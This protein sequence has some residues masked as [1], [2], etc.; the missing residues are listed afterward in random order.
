MIT[1]EEPFIELA[2][3]FALI[4]ESTKIIQEEIEMKSK[5]IARKV[6]IS[7]GPFFNMV[8]FENQLI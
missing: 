1:M 8:P 5:K 7:I 3:Q 2:K 6:K 4:K